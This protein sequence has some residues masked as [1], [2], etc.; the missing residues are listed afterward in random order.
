[1]SSAPI[2]GC[3]MG[4][5][6]FTADTCMLMHLTKHQGSSARVRCKLLGGVSQVD[7]ICARSNLGVILTGLQPAHQRV[8]QVSKK[9][10]G[11]KER[12]TPYHAN[13]Q[14]PFQLQPDSAVS[15]ASKPAPY[16]KVGTTS[17]RPWSVILVTIHPFWPF[18]DILEPLGRVDGV[19]SILDTVA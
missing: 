12:Q 7:A 13:V 9:K 3:A 2:M 16:V 6:L 4:K 18:R 10:E 15:S 1:M 5:G 14:V 11:K 19:D 17:R 8:Y